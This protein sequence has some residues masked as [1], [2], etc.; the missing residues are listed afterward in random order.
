MPSPTSQ[1]PHLI[2]FFAMKLANVEAGL[3]RDE[4]SQ[5]TIIL[6]EEYFP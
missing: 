2:A 6:K 3:A 1:L 4:A 5:F